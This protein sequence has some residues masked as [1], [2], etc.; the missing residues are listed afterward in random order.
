[1]STRYSMKARAASAP[2]VW[3]GHGGSARVTEGVPRGSCGRRCGLS[4]QA[5]Y[6]PA[7]GLVRQVSVGRSSQRQ[8]LLSCRTA[9]RK[10]TLGQWTNGDQRARVGD[11]IELLEASN[12]RSQELWSKNMAPAIG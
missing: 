2:R 1:M 12:Q 5:Q 4:A 10:G 11:G 7:A 3:T 8:Q 9:A 6:D